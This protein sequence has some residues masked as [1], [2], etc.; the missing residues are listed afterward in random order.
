[1]TTAHRP[2][3]H[4]AKGKGDEGG[5]KFLQP[6][7]Q[8]SSRNLP[9]HMNLKRRQ[10]GQGT[11]DEIKKRNFKEDLEKRE[12][13]LKV[14]KSGNSEKD[15]KQAIEESE[16][17]KIEAAP[18][19]V[20]V[21]NEDADDESA[22]ESDDDSEEEGGEDD[23]YEELM[24]ELA[25]IKKE[26]A[27]EAAKRAAEE[28]AE[29]EKQ[30]QEEVLRGNPLLNLAV[31]EQSHTIKRRWDDDVVFRNTCKGEPVKKKR[32]I[33]DTIRN[34]FHKKFLQKYIK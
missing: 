30:R 32:F 7:V 6:S 10:D 3:Y 20:E 23:E 15:N 31:E 29:L 22:E 14:D 9:S 28:A 27:E 5:N 2:T 34:D 13:K 1:M 21:F 19:G 8:T 17:K 18:S 4:P 16:K 33:N 25:R 12:K 26:R 24:A 11:E